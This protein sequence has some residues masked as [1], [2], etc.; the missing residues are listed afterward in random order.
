[1]KHFSERPCAADGLTSYRYD[2]RYGPIMIGAADHADALEQA[3]QSTVHVT[4]QKLK[5]WDG[6]RYVPAF[7][8][9]QA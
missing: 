1:M 6:A 7:K 5:I 3:R 2:G 4:P 9:L 8:R